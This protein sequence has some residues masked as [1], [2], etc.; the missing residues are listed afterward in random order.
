VRRALRLDASFPLRVLVLS[1]Q[2]VDD[3]GGD[4]LSL[5][6]IYFDALK[7]EVAADVERADLFVRDVQ[8]AVALLFSSHSLVFVHSVSL[9]L[10]CIAATLR[11]VPAL[12][13]NTSLVSIVLQCLQP[14]DLLQWTLSLSTKQFSLF[15]SHTAIAA[16]VQRS[17]GM[18]AFDQQILFALIA[19]EASMKPSVVIGVAQMLLQ[20]ITPHSSAPLSSC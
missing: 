20:T 14:A 12:C 8:S 7:A 6:S 16:A 9:C 4:A 18:H 10:R 11:R 17:V 1:Q 3:E 19:A 2:D 15:G 13:G 5:G